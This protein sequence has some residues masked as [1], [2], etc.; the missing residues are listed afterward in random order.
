MT[1]KYESK[2]ITKRGRYGCAKV[3][4]FTVL[5]HYSKA[6]RWLSARDIAI[7]SGL[8]YYSVGRSLSRWISY[9]YVVRRSIEYGGQYEYKIEPKGSKWLYLASRHLP[10]YRIF[11]DELSQWQN[12]LT[13]DVIDYLET[14]PFDEFTRQ[15]SDMISTQ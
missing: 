7:L 12:G 6:D 13:Q 4:A 2:L 14:L 1:T 8:S 3:R 9:G 5:S 15:L 11:I 10:N